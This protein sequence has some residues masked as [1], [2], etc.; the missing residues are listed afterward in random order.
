MIKKTSKKA[1]SK[2]VVKKSPDPFDEVREIA[3][4]TARNCNL[5][6]FDFTADDK[7]ESFDPDR[8]HLVLRKENNKMTVTFVDRHIKMQAIRSG[9]PSTLKKTLEDVS[10]GCVIHNDHFRDRCHYLGGEVYNKTK[11]GFVSG[12]PKCRFLDEKNRPEFGKDYFEKTPLEKNYE[13]QLLEIVRM[14]YVLNSYGDPTEIYAWHYD[15]KRS[16]RGTWEAIKTDPMTFK[17]WIRALEWKIDTDWDAREKMPED[18]PK[19]T[20][21][22]LKAETGLLRARGDSFETRDARRDDII[23][24]YSENYGYHRW[25]NSTPRSPETDKLIKDVRDKSSE[26]ADSGD[27]DMS[28]FLYNVYKTMSRDIPKLYSNSRYSPKELR[29]RYLPPTPFDNWN[30]VVRTKDR[31]KDKKGWIGRDSQ[32]EKFEDDLNWE[33]FD[34]VGDLIN[35][36]EEKVSAKEIFEVEADEYPAKIEGR[37]SSRENL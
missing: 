3:K 14:D 5:S 19:G 8:E 2:K 6:F 18:L 1:S 20:R 29:R 31:L 37:S 7:K 26:L 13:R 22:P 11:Y 36:I 25:E 17:E 10:A 33:L 32:R 27:K 28:D 4:T 24:F 21:N 9:A 12:A 23:S 34:E 35:E 16:A 30:E 15:P